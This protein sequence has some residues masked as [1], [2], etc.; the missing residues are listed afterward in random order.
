MCSWQD[1]SFHHLRRYCKIGNMF[2]AM[3]TGKSPILIICLFFL[4]NYTQ[5]QTCCSAGAPITSTFDIGG[6]GQKGIAFQMNYE[7]N[8]VNL[9]INKNR[10]LED[11]PS[12]RNGQN[13]LFKTDLTLN[14]NWAFSAFLPI[15][16]QRRTTISEDE[17]ASGLG[18]LT[19]MGQYSSSFS[20]NN[21]LKIGL[22]IKLPTGDQYITNVQGINLSPDMQS[23]SGSFDFLGRVSLVSQNVLTTNLTNQTSLSFR[24]NTTNEHFGDPS[25][26]L[27]R[28]FKFGDELT[29]TSMFSY[30]I[31]AQ[32][33]FLLPDLGLQLRYA[34]PNEEQHFA[35]PNSGGYWIG[36]PL[37][38]QFQ[39]NEKTGMRIYGFVP[40]KQYLKGIQI[41]TN[42]RIGVEI[43]YQFSLDRS[44]GFDFE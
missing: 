10:R 26:Q 28:A 12:T 20:D 1:N 24:Y 43:R 8:S 41:T 21:N 5:A 2:V 18:D 38:M 11:D 42:Y 34:T 27:G 17:S 39:P 3:R 31:V 4:W 32:N 23:G 9:L 35:A 37:G 29:L 7:Y 16:I 15:V 25:G 22:G 33:W 40:I 19:L 14:K 36:V 30:L 6:N 13:I 44:S